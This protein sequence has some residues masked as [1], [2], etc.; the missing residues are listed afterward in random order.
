MK[1]FISCSF[2][3]KDLGPANRIKGHF[4]TIFG[5]KDEDIIIAVDPREGEFIEKIKNY[6]IHSDIVVGLFARRDRKP[7]SSSY[8]TVPW[9]IAETTYAWSIGRR[10]IAFVEGGVDRND[11]TFLLP[12]DLPRF[13][14]KGNRLTSEGIRSATIEK[15]FIE[16]LKKEISLPQQSREILRAQI[17]VQILATGTGIH[18]CRFEVRCLDKRNFVP[19]HHGFSTMKRLGSLKELRQVPSC[20]MYVAP[21]FRFTFI[22]PDDIH[23]PEQYLE[24]LSQTDS[25]KIEFAVKLPSGIREGDIFIYEYT[26]TAPDTYFTDLAA[27][28]EQGLEWDYFDWQ[29]FNPYRS[30]EFQI[31]FDREIAPQEGPFLLHCHEVSSPRRVPAG[32]T[33]LD[34]IDW[35]CERTSVSHCYRSRP[36]NARYRQGE[37]LSIRWKPPTDV[38]RSQSGGGIT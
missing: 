32:I 37:V 33:L 15:R 19:I 36:I 27:L 21:F 14:K 30:V 25:N 16:S 4:K 9:V 26:W 7:R 11:V 2:R 13:N 20:K 28:N 24:E 29:L 6:I 23:Q 12:R 18:T 1:I 34:S 35:D 8:S 22:R 31:D 38:P 10:V 17:H 5:L 3:K